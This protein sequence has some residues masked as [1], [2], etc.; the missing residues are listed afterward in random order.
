MFHENEEKVIT[1]GY[2][3]PIIADDWDGSLPGLISESFAPTLAAEEVPGTDSDGNY[4]FG[5]AGRY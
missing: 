3:E 5:L 4:L 1:E 2:R